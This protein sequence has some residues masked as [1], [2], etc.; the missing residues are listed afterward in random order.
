VLKILFLNNYL[1]FFFKLLSAQG[2]T[3]HIKST[4]NLYFPFKRINEEPK[5]K[6]KRGKRE[7]HIR[8][9]T[10]LPITAFAVI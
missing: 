2:I 10:K 5:Y 1:F 6:Y 3:V 9:E 4:A 8:T 7:K